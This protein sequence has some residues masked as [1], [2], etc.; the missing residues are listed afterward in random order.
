[1][2]DRRHFLKASAA[3][4]AGAAGAGLVAVSPLPAQAGDDASSLAAP[5]RAAGDPP[6]ARF[7]RKPPAAGRR[8]MAISSHPLVTRAAIDVLRA[9]GNACDAVLCASVTQAVVEP[10]MTAISGVLS[11]LYYDASRGEVTYVN[12]GMN[13]PLA[14][15]PGFS[16]A[17]VATGRGAAVPGFWGGF[18]A[19]LA[20]H[21]TRSRAEFLRP[22]IAYARNG[23]E[24][25]PFLYGM[26]FQQMSRLGLNEHS[27]EIFMPHGA[28]LSPGKRLVQRGLADT[29]ERLAADGSAFFYHGD[30]A[31]RYCDV[32]QRAG[33]VLTPEDFAS[34]EARWQAPARSTYRGY[35]VVG[36]PPPDNGGT[37]IVEA[38]NML[39]LLDLRR[40]GPPTDSPDTLYQMIRITNEVMAEGAKQTDPNSHRV[41]LDVIV[42]KEYARM[43]FELLQMAPARQ[44]AAE[45]TVYP[46]SNHLTVVD[47]AGNV[48][49]VLHSCMSMPWS[50]GLFVDGVSIVASGVHFLRVMPRPGDRASAY[51]APNMILRDGRPVLASGSPS[52]SL[53]GNILQNITNVLDFGMT[54]EESVHRPRFGG[55]PSGTRPGGP[56]RN[57]I[58]VDV[59][60]G[61]R[62]EVARRGLD[63]EV[64]NP[65]NMY[66]GSFEGVRI[67]ERTGERS[68][69][70][71]PRRTS[72]AEGY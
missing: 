10:H 3:G 9:G 19:A 71:D 39:E 44:Q 24:I 7:G 26:M 41:P 62:A 45:P 66:L 55:W 31:R 49:T 46:G 51:V 12:G 43:R 30:F 16:A 53:V 35:E 37:H 32:V 67:D 13:A 72:H 48:A 14:P 70:G 54:L 2:T 60:E 57:Y 6:A 27:R 69:C 68:A 65:W 58:E 52:V 33:G 5:D 40:L 50:N 42:S 47:A 38:L 21:G 36:S 56:M 8:G 18:E 28:L 63:L 29:L 20:R 25:Y 11:M 4:L 64:V 23:F 22:A 15:L 17:D 61:V 59:R 34:Y 1:M